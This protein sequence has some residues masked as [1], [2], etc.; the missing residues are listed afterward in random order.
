MAPCI[1]L[2]PAVVAGTCEWGGSLQALKLQVLNRVAV[3]VYARWPRMGH[4]AT[5]I[6]QGRRNI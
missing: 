3:A 2:T 5:T 1:P 6:A 4:M